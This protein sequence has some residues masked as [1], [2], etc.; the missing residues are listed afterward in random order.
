MAELGP[1]I[2]PSLRRLGMLV[3]AAYILRNRCLA[4]SNNRKAI[5]DSE[6]NLRRMHNLVT[7]HRSFCLC[8]PFNGA[9]QGVTPKAD[10]DLSCDTFIMKPTITTRQIPS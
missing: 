5:A 7:R 4:D 2:C 6:L 9:L 1:F 10:Y 8:C 3:K